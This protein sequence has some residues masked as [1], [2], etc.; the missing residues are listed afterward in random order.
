MEENRKLFMTQPDCCSEGID[1]RDKGQLKA[2]D[3]EI[4]SR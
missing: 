3:C 4:L 2:D 1:V